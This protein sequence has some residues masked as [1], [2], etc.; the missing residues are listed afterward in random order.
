MRDTDFRC[1]RSA[2]VV[3]TSSNGSTRWSGIAEEAR[4]LTPC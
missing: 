1:S 2:Y 4:M 3:G